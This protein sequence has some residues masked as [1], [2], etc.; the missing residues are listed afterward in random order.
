MKIPLEKC[1]QKG[2]SYGILQMDM[3]ML[4]DQQGLTYISSVWTLVAVENTC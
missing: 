2:F 3:P 1:N 4:A